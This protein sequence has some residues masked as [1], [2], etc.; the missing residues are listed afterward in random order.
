MITYRPSSVDRTPF[1]PLN[2]ISS[3]TPGPVFFKLNVEPFVKGGLKI[4]SNEQGLLIKM[5][6]M[7]IYGK[8]LNIVFRTEKAFGLNLDM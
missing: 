7:L 1:I 5:A 4:C 6:A 8:T 2:G 3:E